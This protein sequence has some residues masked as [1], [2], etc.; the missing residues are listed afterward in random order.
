MVSF[1]ILKGNNDAN[2]LD[3]LVNYHSLAQSGAENNG[4]LIFT[5]VGSLYCIGYWTIIY[6]HYY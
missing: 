2:N 4:L 5:V 1:S 6:Y 3:V